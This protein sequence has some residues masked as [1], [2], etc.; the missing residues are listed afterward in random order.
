MRAGGSSGSNLRAF[1]QRSSSAVAEGVGGYDVDE[2]LLDVLARGVE[3]RD[4]AAERAA[5]I[6]RLHPAKSVREPLAG[7]ASSHLGACGELICKSDRAVER[8]VGIRRLDDSSA[9]VNRRVII[10]WPVLAD[11]G[12]AFDSGDDAID[13]RVARRH[14]GHDVV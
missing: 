2:Q 14:R 9:L 6:G 12:E 8:T 7:Y 3:R 13:V 10:D 5:V 1:S 11:A 4:E